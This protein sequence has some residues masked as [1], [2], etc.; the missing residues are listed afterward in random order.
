[1]IRALVTCTQV[2]ESGNRERTVVPVTDVCVRA[3]CNLLSRASSDASAH[4]IATSRGQSHAY[5]GAAAVRHGLLAHNEAMPERFRIV[6]LP[7]S[8]A[9]R[10][11][12]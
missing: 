6:G 9:R 5:A 3:R 11:I 8:T 12:R 2:C 1:M 10:S 4:I 7:I